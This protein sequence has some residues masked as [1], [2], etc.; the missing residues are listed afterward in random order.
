MT[1]MI[2]NQLFNPAAFHTD[3]VNGIHSRGPMAIWSNLV[4]TFSQLHK[5]KRFPLGP[6]WNI[7]VLHSSV[8]LESFPFLSQEPF[9]LFCK[10][11]SQRQLGRWS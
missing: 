3:S 1:A 6:T 10:V 9:F 4:P 5:Q 2:R 8:S 11:F 7:L